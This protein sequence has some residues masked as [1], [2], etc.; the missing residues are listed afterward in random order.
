MKFLRFER[1]KFHPWIQPMFSFCKNFLDNKILF[2]LLIKT[3]SNFFFLNSFP[4]FDLKA[5]ISDLFCKV[6][7]TRRKVA[8]ATSV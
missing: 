3:H 5:S 6:M 1:K 4:Y 7:K 2:F 8:I